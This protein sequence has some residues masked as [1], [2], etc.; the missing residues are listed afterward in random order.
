MAMQRDWHDGIFPE[1]K[2]GTVQPLTGVRT[3]LHASEGVVSFY[4]VLGVGN[5]K[6]QRPTA[7]GRIPLLFRSFHSFMLE[8]DRLSGPLGLRLL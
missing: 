2:L 7:F 8:Y 4:C 6:N 1:S 3:S 5:V